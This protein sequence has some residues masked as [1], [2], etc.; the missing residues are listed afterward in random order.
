MR[1][2]VALTAL[3][4]VLTLALAPLGAGG[5]APPGPTIRHQF[6]TAGLPPGGPMELAKFINE[7]APGAETVAHTHPG[8]VVG[9]LIEGENTCLCGA[10]TRTYRLGESL[11]ERPGEVAVYRNTGTTRARVMAS[12][13]LP[14]GAPL[15]T[16]QPGAPPPAVAPTA[17]YLS[18]VDA[19]IPA[20]PYEVAH[21]V[22]DFAPGAQT[23]PHTHPGQTVVTVLEGALTFRTGGTERTFGV[24]ESFS[25]PGEM[26]GQAL[27]TGAVRTTVLV[28]YLLPQGAPL[29]TP[30]PQAPGLPATGAGGAPPR[31]PGGW[32]VAA[33]AAVISRRLGHG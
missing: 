26:V 2:R 25:E 8:L 31:A 24:G 14:K 20:G 27:N 29:S 5:Q 23:P 16:P 22:L 30:V 15:S 10:L 19:A 9:T 11:I 13:V 6:R 4:L 21:A 12:I 28:T 7:Y 17:L 3:A 1:R 33:A 32:L 18:R